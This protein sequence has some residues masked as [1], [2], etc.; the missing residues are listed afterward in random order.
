MLIENGLICAYVADSQIISAT[1]GTNDRRE[2]EIDDA[3]LPWHLDVVTTAVPP[4][5]QDTRYP[6]KSKDEGL[7]LMRDLEER[8]RM[9]RL[10]EGR[11]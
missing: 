3:E 2:G 5:E 9:L 1:V 7:D 10:S 8:T 6:L 11:I 4:A